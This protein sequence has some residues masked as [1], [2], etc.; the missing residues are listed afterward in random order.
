MKKTIRYIVMI[1]RTGKTNVR[2]VQT[3]PELAWYCVW[4][5]RGHEQ[6]AAINLRKLD[7]VTVFCPRIRFKKS[8]R[9]GVVWVTEAMFP[10]YLFAHFALPKMHRQI[11]YAHGVSG[12]VR[13]GDRYPTIEDA[14][15][16]KLRNHTGD[17]E[18]TELNYKL[19]EG[20]QVKITEGALAGLEAVITKVLSA[21]QRVKIL[22]EFLGTKV[23][24]EV[25]NSDVLPQSMYPLPA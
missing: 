25:G 20:V 1:S 24:A 18:V 22:M 17:A 13:F 6:I 8:S 23:E 15:L 2:T 12:I 11:Q 7:G 19:S 9:R 16:A 5:Q 10:G 14:V 3:F 4:S 21:K